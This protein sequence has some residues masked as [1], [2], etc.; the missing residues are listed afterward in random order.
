MIA[1]L[2]TIIVAGIAFSA[3]DGDHATPTG[4]DGQPDG[5]PGAADGA[6]FPS[7]ATPVPDLAILGQP[8]PD[9][10]IPIQAGWLRWLDPTS[11]QFVME[12]DPPEQGSVDLTFVDA[13]GNAIQ[14]CMPGPTVAD[15]VRYDVG[16]CSPG[17]GQP[18]LAIALFETPLALLDRE[19]DR[20]PVQLDATVSRDGK[21]LWLASAVRADE[22]WLVEVRSIDIAGWYVRDTRELRRIPVTAAV[23]QPGSPGGWHV[24]PDAVV[25]PTIR[26]SPS[27]TTL[28][29]T[30]TATK[31]FEPD[32]GLLQQERI[33]FP[34]SLD[35]PLAPIEIAFPFGAA[36]DL[37]CD[38]SRSAWA[39]ERHYVTL[40]QHGGPDGST[41]P[42]V[43]IENPD[44]MTRDV[45][46][47]PV[48]PAGPGLFDDS[49]WLLDGER[50]ILYRWAGRSGLTL[51]TLDIARR[52]GATIELAPD[53]GPPAGGIEPLPGGVTA[54]RN[55]VWMQLATAGSPDAGLKLAGS[56]DGRYL[57]TTA[58]ID[59]V[60]FPD[61]FIQEPRTLEWVL[62]T[63]SNVVVGR[64]DAP[65]PIDQIALGPGG[66]PLLEMVT[67]GGYFGPGPASDW[68]APLWFIDQLTGQPLEVIGHLHGPAGLSPWLL[69]PIVGTLAGF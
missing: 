48:V 29:V 15:T 11:G 22:S 38:A 4:S 43:R 64:A 6:V 16:L 8:A 53:G 24:D 26:A 67:P 37:A 66:G 65:A 45:A 39:T 7:V 47:G 34:G 42:F 40:C 25:K 28:S 46:V 50:G 54:D 55:L 3:L 44:D 68:D 30:L 23:A 51:S 33:T 10:L 12:A 35:S 5:S 21:W 41:Q 69:S 27:G 1:V 17:R 52:S 32:G 14:V 63:R 49:S 62:D 2:A 18:R 60:F 31:P 61:A 57:Y 13:D 56:G 20:A 9:R 59:P 58:L 19:Q 36:G